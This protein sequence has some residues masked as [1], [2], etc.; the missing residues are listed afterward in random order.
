LIV[1]MAV[2]DWQ[3]SGETLGVATRTATA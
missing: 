1:A 3:P 2:P